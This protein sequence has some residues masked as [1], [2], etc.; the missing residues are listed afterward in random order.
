M[1]KLAIIDR[2]AEIPVHAQLPGVDKK[3]PDSALTD[4][5]VTIT[6]EMRKEEKQP[7]GDCCRC[8]ISRG[9]LARTVALPKRL[10]PGVAASASTELC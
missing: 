3:D 5:R 9:A 1:P 6:G 4:T 10:F 7:K 2:D 8:E